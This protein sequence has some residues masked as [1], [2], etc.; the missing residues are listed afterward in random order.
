M[1]ALPSANPTTVAVPESRPVS[2]TT[3]KGS[4]G[5]VAGGSESLERVACRA[6]SRKPNHVESPD[7]GWLGSGVA[8]RICAR[9][10]R[11]I[12]ARMTSARKKMKILITRY[13]ISRAGPPG[14]HLLKQL[15]D[16]AS[17]RR[18]LF[19][20]ES[21]SV[22]RWLDHSR[23]FAKCTGQGDWLHTRRWHCR[24]SSRR[25]H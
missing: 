5:E 8:G 6:I 23:S 16:P 24:L 20:F 15:R 1:L 21:S 25:R 12:H 2:I 22:N 17:S 7:F 13:Q 11:T 19:H 10:R 14:Q 4:L 3:P 18:P 9:V